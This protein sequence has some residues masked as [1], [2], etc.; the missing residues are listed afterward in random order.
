MR[1]PPG[2]TASVIP[3]ADDGERELVPMS[4]RFVLLQDGKAPRRVTNVRDDK[5]RKPRSKRRVGSPG[6]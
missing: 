6:S 4:W 3:K 5:I 2:W 1:A